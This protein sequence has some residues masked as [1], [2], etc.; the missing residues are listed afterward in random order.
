MDR[1]A[2]FRSQRQE[3]R[4]ENLQYKFLSRRK[5]ILVENTHHMPCNVHKILCIFYKRIFFVRKFLIHKLSNTRLREAK[6]CP[7]AHSKQCQTWNSTQA[8][9][10]PKAVCTPSTIPEV[11]N[12]TAFQNQGGTMYRFLGLTPDLLNQNL[13]W[14]WGVEGLGGGG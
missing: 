13:P 2:G 4:Y 5:W 1:K 9:V 11:P 7:Q 3:F 8:C 14:G 12:P 10:I 6:W